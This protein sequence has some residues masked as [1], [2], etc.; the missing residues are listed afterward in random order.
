MATTVVSG[1]YAMVFISPAT[2]TTTWKAV[3]HAT[4]HTL[5]IKMAARDTSNK[6]TAN[7]VTKASGR[8]DVTGTLTG[9]Y[10]DNDKYNLE[11]FMTLILARNPVLM[12][13]GKETVQFNGVPD[14]TTTGLTHFYASGQFI[15]SDLSAD[16][17]DQQNSTYTVTFEHYTGFQMNKLITS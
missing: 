2:T 17:P 9:M 13:F 16:F 15:I 4:S 7:Y 14:T 1:E 6:G 3:A 10:I 8:L 11:D 12:I 5:S